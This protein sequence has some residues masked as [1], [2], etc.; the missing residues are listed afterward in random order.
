MSC[1]TLQTFRIVL[2]GDDTGL[3]RDTLEQGEHDVVAEGTT[4]SDMVR[5]VLF[6]DPDVLVFDM[7]PEEGL[8]A[9][10]RIYQER[11]VPAVAI[12]DRKD[13]WQIR[14][15]LKQFILTYLLKPVELHQLEPAIH[16][17]CARYETYRETKEEISKLQ[18]VLE[19][20]KIIERAKGVLM[21]RY[22]WSEHDAF[23]RLQRTA[24]NQRT[25][26]AELAQAVLSGATVKL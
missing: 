1:I 15:H 2:I 9:L 6:R 7:P 4:A 26:M 22:R 18:R 23:R 21:K 5:A 20:R 14:Q 8:E 12:G 19:N 17:A 3:L 10:G 11:I 16:V 24:M 25:S 13:E